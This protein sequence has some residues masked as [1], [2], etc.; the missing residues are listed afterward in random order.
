MMHRL[1]YIFGAFLSLPLLPVIV[2]QGK[3]IIKE[4]PRL[5]EA[6]QPEGTL[7]FG[8]KNSKKVLFLGESTVAG[9]GVKT[10]R[11]GFAG[12]VATELTR[13]Y[14]TNIDWKV[15]ARSGYTSK[16]VR[17]KLIRRVGEF[18]PDLII[19]GLGGNDAFKLNT[20]WN[21]RKEI[22]ALIKAYCIK[23]YV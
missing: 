21:W 19:I 4:V 20:P 5:P 15:V 7:E 12:S 13:L 23:K 16:M 17:N 18:E 6:E 22:K 11:Q 10:H 8:Y 1:K 9:V 2:L 3:K 14:Q